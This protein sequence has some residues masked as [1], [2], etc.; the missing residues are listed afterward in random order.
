MITYT[1]WYFYCYY[2]ITQENTT[3]RARTGLERLN[4]ENDARIVY[5]AIRISE[6]RK[7]S[8][9]KLNGNHFL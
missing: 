8:P 5:A 1:Y 7:A 2:Y 6:Q 4:R 3:R 9:H